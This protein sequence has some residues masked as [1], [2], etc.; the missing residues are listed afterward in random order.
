[1]MHLAYRPVHFL[2]V[3]RAQALTR[4][5][6]E[7]WLVKEPVSNQANFF[8]KRAAEMR[9]LGSRATTAT[10]QSKFEDIAVEYDT[11]A[12]QSEKEALRPKG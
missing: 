12:R 6:A 4:Q 9:E 3:D 11:L 8:R 10:Q 2:T 5:L 1:M 7:R